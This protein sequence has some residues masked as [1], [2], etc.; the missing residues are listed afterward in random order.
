MLKIIRFKGKNISG[1]TKT[2]FLYKIDNLFLMDNHRMALWCWSR[3]FNTN[4]KYNLIHIDKHYDTT[5][6]IIDKKNIHLIPK[7]IDL[8]NANDYDEYQIELNHEKIS[9]FTWDNYLPIFHFLKKSEISQYSFFTHNVGELSKKL[10]LKI[11]E[12]SV[13]KLIGIKNY[14]FENNFTIINLDIDYFF[15]DFESGYQILFSEEI[16][17]IIVENI[18]LFLKSDNVCI[19]IALSPDCCGGWENSIN[20]YNKYFSKHIGKLDF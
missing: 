3:Y 13:S 20:F 5:D 12:H 15:S 6:G 2:N 4:K 7:R 10:K 9:L 19:T 17:N 16:I 8:L 14:V 1:S 18:I 11:H